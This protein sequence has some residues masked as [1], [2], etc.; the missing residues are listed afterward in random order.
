MEL[1]IIFVIWGVVLYI[2]RLKKEL[3]QY[4]KYFTKHDDIYVPSYKELK[5]NNGQ[6]VQL[7]K[8]VFSQLK[9]EPLNRRR[10]IIPGFKKRLNEI[11]MVLIGKKIDY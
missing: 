9:A 4:R 2:V 10:I 11:T 7:I 8:F 1:L 3:G 5:E 6:I